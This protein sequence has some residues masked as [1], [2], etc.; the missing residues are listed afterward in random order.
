MFD[1]E[2]FKKACSSGNGCGFLDIRRESDREYFISYLK[3]NSIPA[4]PYVKVD[5]PYV[6]WDFEYRECFGYGVTLPEH[7][8]IYSIADFETVT[9]KADNA[10]ILNFLEV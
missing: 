8:Q 2:K 5:A 1:F 7:R 4:T 3:D 9:L 6:Y 10:D